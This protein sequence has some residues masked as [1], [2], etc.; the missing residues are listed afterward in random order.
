MGSYGIDSASLAQ[1]GAGGGAEGAG[2]W[3]IGRVAYSLSLFVL[4]ASFFSPFAFGAGLA[5]GFVDLR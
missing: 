5:A 3:R 4:F 2:S 1:G